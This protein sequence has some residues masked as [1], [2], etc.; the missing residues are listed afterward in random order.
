M[1]RRRLL[2][3]VS[4]LLASIAL[5]IALG[6]PAYAQEEMTLLNMAR[7]AQARAYV[8][9]T[10]PLAPP[11]ADLDYNAFR[12][13][14][15]LPGRAAMLPHGSR[16]AYDLLPPGLYFPD[17]IAFDQITPDGVREI[18]FSPRLFSYQPRYFDAIPDTSPGAGFTG[19]RLRYPI[20]AADRLDE[21]LVLQ[22]ASYFRAI[23]EAMV[24]GLSARTV[25]IGTGG[26]GAEEFPRF[27]HL[28][29][30]PAQGDGVRLEGM[31]DSPSLTGHLDLTLR[32]GP[33][34][35]MDIV[36]TVFPRVDIDDIGI[37]PL[38]SM[39]L[40]GPML[41]AVS[42]DFRPRVHDSDVLVIE[43]GA[44]EVLWRP[45]ANP[46]GVETSAFADVSPRRFGLYQTPR[47]Y[48]DFQD[49]EARYHDRP[50]AFVEPLEPWGPGA[51]MLVELPTGDEFLDNIVAFWRP[52]EVLQ[53][54][55]EYRYAYRLTWTREAP[56][57][58]G[59]PQILQ[60]RSGKE[61]DQPGH[62]RYVVDVAT[63]MAGLMPLIS[64]TEGS[65]VTGVST[66][67]LPDGQST[68]T[69]FLLAPGE[70]DFA[71]IRLSLRSEDG[72]PQSPVWLHRWTRARDGGV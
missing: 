69:T 63:S 35:V 21:V 43:N 51:V 24:Y 57:T 13:I 32:P 65:E 36:T 52:Q 48:E 14:R 70:L 6:S 49:T 38:T 34:T 7:A 12:G 61:H 41:A 47:A 33:E 55:E 72:T 18:A 29:L 46:R 45:V 42:D 44:G 68:R 8:P 60:S 66:F 19:V 10:T 4:A 11:F 54:G 25:A 31:V 56:S 50:S 17:P 64:S 59:L 40:K 27:T 1:N 26:G 37:A 22:G 23:G 5:P 20:N 71:E 15:P 62:R 67:A 53:Q 16:F 58:A 2:V 28:R 39:Y 30:H 9:N 3:K